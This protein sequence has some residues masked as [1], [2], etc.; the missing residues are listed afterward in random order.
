MLSTG[1]V[2]SLLRREREK[3][4]VNITFQYLLLFT[5]KGNIYYILGSI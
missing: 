2:Q 4:N 5:A 1:N 3:M